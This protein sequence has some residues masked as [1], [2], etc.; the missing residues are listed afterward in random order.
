MYSYMPLGEHVSI[1]S[2]KFIKSINIPTTAVT[3][4]L[5]QESTIALVHY[6]ID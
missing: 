5:I 2:L 4:K 1:L 6:N 3:S